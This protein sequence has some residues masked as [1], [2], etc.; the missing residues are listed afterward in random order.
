MHGAG[1][2]ISYSLI[3]IPNFL[4]LLKGEDIENAN[5]YALFYAERV[6]IC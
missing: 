5:G 3:L 4:Y 2:Q 6:R 1:V